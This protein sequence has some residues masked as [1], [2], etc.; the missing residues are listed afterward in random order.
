LILIGPEWHET[1]R[2]F[3][4][5]LGDY[6]PEYQRRFLSFAPDVDTAC[7]ILAKWPE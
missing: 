3:Y 4:Q 1:F 5:V 7:Q 6:V 2:H